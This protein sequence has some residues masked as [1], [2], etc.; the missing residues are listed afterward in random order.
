MRYLALLGAAAF[1]LTPFG[2]LAQDLEKPTAASAVPPAAPPLAA[3]TVGEKVK[4]DW[5][6]YDRGEKGHLTKAE[7]SRWLTDLRAVNKEAAPDAAWLDAAF[8]QTDTNKDQ[9]VSPEE[10]TASLSKAS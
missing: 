8:V 3:M 5:P 9:K 10:L 7:L 2:L 4:A 6:L 1:G